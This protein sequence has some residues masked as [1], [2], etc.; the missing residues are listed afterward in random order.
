MFPSCS[1]HVILFLCS[2]TILV[3][4]NSGV[5]RDGLSSHWI[6]DGWKWGGFVSDHC[7]V[8]VELYTNKDLDKGDLSLEKDKDIQFFVGGD[9]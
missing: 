8:Y 3:S 4:G 5:V 1:K 7:P 9:S 6:P 2:L